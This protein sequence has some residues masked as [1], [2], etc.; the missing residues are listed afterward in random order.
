MLRE[1]STDVRSGHDERQHA[2]TLKVLA[3]PLPRKK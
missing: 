2:L 1:R 3:K